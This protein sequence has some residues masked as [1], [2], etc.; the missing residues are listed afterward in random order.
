MLQHHPQSVLW[1]NSAGK[2]NPFELVQSI[3]AKRSLA[4]PMDY[5]MNG[6]TFIRIRASI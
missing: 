2:F 5:L 1:H 3:Q 4:P 6:K